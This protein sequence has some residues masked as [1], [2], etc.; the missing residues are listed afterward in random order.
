[1][2]YAGDG[3][4]GYDWRFRQIAA[5][6]PHVIG[7]KS[8]PPCGTLPSRA[9]PDLCTASSASV[10]CIPQQNVSGHLTKGPIPQELSPSIKLQLNQSPPTLPHHNDV[11]YACCITMSQL[12]A[13]HS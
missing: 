11:E 2:Q 4:M 10:L 12:P 3:W 13:V 9:R 1:M 8:I 6:K 7:P 5:T